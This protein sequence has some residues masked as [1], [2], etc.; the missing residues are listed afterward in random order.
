MCDKSDIR[1]FIALNFL[2]SDN[3]N[4]IQDDLSLLESGILDSTGVLE[5][6]QFLENRYSIKVDYEEI[7]RSNLGSVN[8]IYDFTQRKI[9]QFV[10]SID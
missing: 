7:V 1:K 6:V 8:S 10:E 5:L 9:H 2:F 3:E 4:D